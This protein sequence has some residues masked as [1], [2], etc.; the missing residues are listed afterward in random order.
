[1]DYLLGWGGLLPEAATFPLLADRLQANVTSM[2]SDVL[3]L[4]KVDNGYDH[5]A[6]TE[7]IASISTRKPGFVCIVLLPSNAE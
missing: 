2:T 7:I 4:T 3:L 1:L 5:R 6:G